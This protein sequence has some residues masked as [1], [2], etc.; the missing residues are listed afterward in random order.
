MFG[1]VGAELDQHNAGGPLLVTDPGTERRRMNGV[2]AV[3]A[4]LEAVRERPGS[5]LN[6][7]VIQQRRDIGGMNESAVGA[8]K[9]RLSCAQPHSSMT[10]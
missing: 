7:G 6:D 4:A 3:D 1:D 10:G 2:C 8:G 5:F 9:H